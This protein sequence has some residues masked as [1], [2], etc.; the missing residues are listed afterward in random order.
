MN[1]NEIAGDIVQVSHLVDS[2]NC[3]KELEK[4]NTIVCS[5]LHTSHLLMQKMKVAVHQEDVSVKQEDQREVEDLNSESQVE[6]D[7]NTLLHHQLQKIFGWPH[8]TQIAKGLNV[9]FILM[10]CN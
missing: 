8:T 9:T 5:I 3:E 10:N 6:N 4:K 2:Q 7:S 1:I